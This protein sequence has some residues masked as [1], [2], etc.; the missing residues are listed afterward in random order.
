MRMESF[1]YRILGPF[2]RQSEEKLNVGSPLPGFNLLMAVSINS[3]V[4]LFTVSIWEEFT[5]F[6]TISSTFLISSVSSVEL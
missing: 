4:T 1:S 5:L 3:G 2:L 6:L